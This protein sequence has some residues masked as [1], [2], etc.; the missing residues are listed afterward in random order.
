MKILVNADAELT[1]SQ[2]EKLANHLVEKRREFV[3]MLDVLNRQIATKEDCS[4][5]DAAEAASLQEEIARASSIADQ[6]NKM[7]T[8]IE[9]ALTRLENGRYGVSETSGT[10]ISYERLLL[11]PWAR[12]GSND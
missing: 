1:Y 4:I 8:D 7:I 5:T 9:H 6:H 10:P 12:T 3:D 11:I 2:L